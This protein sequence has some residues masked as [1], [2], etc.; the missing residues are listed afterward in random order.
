MVAAVD[1]EYAKIPA[2]AC[3]KKCRGSC[4]PVGQ[5]MT[6]F[7]R[8]RIIARTGVAPNGFA[9]D[10]IEAMRAESCNLLTADGLCSVHDIRPAICRVWGVDRQLACPNGCDGA[11]SVPS[12]E[13][14]RHIAAVRKAVREYESPL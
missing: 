4:S 12:G 2:I 9:G 7:E 3:Q 10:T 14:I 11:G 1:A 6:T 13:C 8:D 5:L